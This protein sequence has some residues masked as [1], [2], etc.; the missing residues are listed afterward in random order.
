MI[1]IVHVLTR[2]NVGGPSVMLVDLVE[3]LDRQQFRQTIIR[4][5]GVA[6]EGDYLAQRSVSADVI[7]LGGLRRSLGVVRE[8]QSLWTLTRTLRRLAPDV[9]HTHMAKAGVV[10]RVAA[11]LARV[12]NRIHTFHGHLLHGYFS[13]P[14][15]KFFVV[16]E[17][18]LRRFTTFALV[19]GESTRRDLLAARIVTQARSSVV[20]PG[21]RDITPTPQPQSRVQLGLP[22]EGQMVGFVGRLTDIKRPDRFLELARAIPDAHFALIG[23]GP[24]RAQIH[25]QAATLPNVT[26]VDFTSDLGVV[27]GA[28]DLVVLTSDNEG[29]PLSLMEAASAR[30][31]VVALNVGGVS[32]IIEH[33]V[34]GLLVE[35]DVDL[36]GSVRRLLN[37]SP[38]RTRL[39]TQAHAHI[40]RRCSMAAYLHQHA[41]LYRECSNE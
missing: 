25:A 19:V 26:L 3:G 34:T 22:T 39:A 11:V 1:H 35:R 37:D 5:P 32:E 38:L 24:L 4:G 28:L 10:G 7:T 16:V 20:Y 21:V 17:R 33:E 2:T 40:E 9:V 36:V 8:V 23:N 30:V 12:P 14:V 27:F 31:P 41:Q 29:V 15:A 18:I 6:S 13:A